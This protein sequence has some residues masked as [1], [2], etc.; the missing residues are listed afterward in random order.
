MILSKI[1]AW[2]PPDAAP[3]SIVLMGATKIATRAVLPQL[4]TYDAR[5]RE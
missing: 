2:I 4:R 5:Q 1:V 3:F